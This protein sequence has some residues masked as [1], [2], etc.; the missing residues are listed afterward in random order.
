MNHLLP[1]DPRA[2]YEAHRAEID[3]ALRTALWRGTYILGEDVQAL[4]REFAAYLGVREVCG[5][6]SGTDA[7][8]L[9]Q[10]ACGIG[11][12][13]TVYTVAHTAVATVAA[14]EIC[15]AQPFL[16]D[17]DPATFTL[18]PSRLEDAVRSGSRG[19]RDAVIAVHLYGHPADLDGIGAVCRRH[20]LVLIEDC[21]Q[22]HGARWNGRMT[23]GFGLAAAFSFYPTKNLGALGDGGAVATS[24]LE[25]AARLRLLR[26]YGW[27]KRYV[28]EI[29]G[30][31]SRLDELQAAILRVKLRHL[32]AENRRRGEI[33]GMY[34]KCASESRLILPAVRPGA[35][36]V[37][38]QYVVRSSEREALRAGLMAHGIGTLVHY[39]VPVHVQPAYRDRIAIGAG[40][41]PET[42]KA[43]REILSLPMHPQLTDEDAG[44]VCA[45]L[46]SA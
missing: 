37:W 17:I 1:A 23:G 25:V 18:D 38:H 9:A 22:S 26:E 42:E 32:D 8:I 12:G 46:L 40:G 15:G 33:A 27:R 36:H 45:A 31:N 3:G 10:K 21:A 30:M 2:S 28:S 7:L 4:E 19:S 11:P 41:L 20:E 24:D 14:V 13:S 34:S 43:A 44:R 29:P 6:A 5:V 16:V 39:P 35:T